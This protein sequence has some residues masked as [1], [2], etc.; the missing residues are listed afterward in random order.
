[1]NNESV[2]AEE[3]IVMVEMLV[4]VLMLVMGRWQSSW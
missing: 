2:K 1:M 3:V 4:L